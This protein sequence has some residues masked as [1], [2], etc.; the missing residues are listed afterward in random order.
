MDET[1]FCYNLVENGLAKKKR[2]HS[3]YVWILHFKNF[4]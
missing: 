3:R 4:G 2:N 1:D